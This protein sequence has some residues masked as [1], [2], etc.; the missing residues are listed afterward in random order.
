MDISQEQRNG[1]TGDF[2]GYLSGAE[3]KKKLGRRGGLWVLKGAGSFRG[4]GRCKL[5]QPG[6]LV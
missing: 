4:G 3:K 5:E 6:S 2:Q 1:Q